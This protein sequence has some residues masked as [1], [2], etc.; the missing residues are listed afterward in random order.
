MIIGLSGYARS[1]KDT[2]AR[3]LVEEFG[4]KRLAFADK[5]R[6]FL[7][8]IDPILNDGYRLNHV[9]TEYSWDTAKDRDE[10]RRLLQETGLAARKMFGPDFWVEQAFASVDPTDRVVVTDV[11]FPNEADYIR[12]LDGYVWR[13][14]R[15]S[16]DAVNNHISEH[17]LN[18]Y[19]FD[20]IINN[21]STVEDLNRAIR[22]NLIS[23]LR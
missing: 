5:I 6:E 2:A 22:N 8:E 17:A 18:G 12:D 4:F 13:I 20:T 14:N 10:V 1:G 16:V 15:D 23:A 11:R 9:V 21:N 19:T 7:L 3:I